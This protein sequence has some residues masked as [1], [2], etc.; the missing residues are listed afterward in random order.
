MSEQ[1][2]QELRQSQHPRYSLINCNVLEIGG[3]FFSFNNAYSHDKANALIGPAGKE[4]LELF[5]IFWMSYLSQS[6]YQ[7]SHPIPS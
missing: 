1:T 6:K 2:Y 4:Q 5:Y 7:N 3:F